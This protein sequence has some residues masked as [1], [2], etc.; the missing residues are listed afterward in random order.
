MKW[1]QGTY[2]HNSTQSSRLWV[3]SAACS[4][5][6]H[7]G[8]GAGGVSTWSSASRGNSHGQEQFCMALVLRGIRSALLHPLPSRRLCSP[9]G[10]EA[11]TRGQGLAVPPPLRK[12]E[13]PQMS[14]G[15]CGYFRSHRTCLLWGRREPGI[16]CLPHAPLTCP[17][18]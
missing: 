11:V 6:T 3:G 13:C 1:G 15:H 16:R 8:I 7:G 2:P 4:M 10:L 17:S 18:V 9:R 5:C 14:P 12:T